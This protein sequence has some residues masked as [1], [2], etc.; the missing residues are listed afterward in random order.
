MKKRR[1]FICALAIVTLLAFAANAGRWL[2]IDDPRQSDAILVIA[3]ETNYRPVRGLELLSHGYGSKLVL[4]APARDRVYQWRV[5]A[6]A[7]YERKLDA[8]EGF[9][10]PDL[11]GEPLEPR[12][13]TS[14]YSDT[15]DRSLAN[16]AFPV[17]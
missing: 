4:D 6:L 7:E 17:A 9:E 11:G 10:L 12:V 5:E 1:I 3:G 14:V 15:A 8:P 16:L 13:F 2:V